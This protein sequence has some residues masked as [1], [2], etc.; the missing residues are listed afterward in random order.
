MAETHV[1]VLFENTA[2]GMEQKLVNPT[3]SLVRGILEEAGLDEEG[4]WTLKDSRRIRRKGRERFGLIRME[5]KYGVRSLRVWCKPRG[6][7][8]SFEYSLVP[9]PGLDLD[10]AFGMLSR[11]NPITLRILESDALP[12]AFVGRVMDVPPLNGRAAKRI[13]CVEV[14]D[15]GVSEN[16]AQDSD[17]DSDRSAFEGSA[18]KDIS[19]D[20]LPSVVRRIKEMIESYE[21]SVRQARELD[22]V[23]GATDSELASLRLGAEELGRK[24]EEMRS[25][26]ERL[27]DELESARKKREGMEAKIRDREMERQ[28]WERARAPH[29]MEIER[30]ASV[31]SAIGVGQSVNKKGRKK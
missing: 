15:V 28:E 21:E 4:S 19:D 30:L 9:P 11:V 14:D 18:S 7:D 2:K 29:A 16:N 20:L 6:N 10:M 8:T 5:S 3:V 22:S 25:E 24:E 1:E 17:G 12:G 26:M 31:L 27:R 23:I 13:E